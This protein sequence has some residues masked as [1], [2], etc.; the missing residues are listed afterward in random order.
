MKHFRAAF[1]A[2]LAALAL[3]LSGCAGVPG[4]TASQQAIRSV[5]VPAADGVAGALLVVPVGS[6]AGS[7][8]WPAVILYP[9]A[10]GLRPVFGELARSI[11]DHGYVVLVPN[12]FYRSVAFD[13]TAAT[14]AP[15]LPA[16]AAMQRGMGWRQ[17]ATDDAVIADARAF[18]SY[19]DALP[20]VDRTRPAAALGVDIGGAHAFMAAR[21]LPH[22]VAAVAV[23]HPS[24]IATAR[25]NSPHLFVGESRAAY[26][27]EIAGPDDV[28]EPEDKGDLASAFNAA[29][30]AA[31]VTVVPAGHG[32]AVADNG[33]FDAAARDAFVDAALVL[34]D[35]RLK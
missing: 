9:D 35:Q 18:M 5:S 31:E 15:P 19:L 33:E 23:A 32:Y 28:R 14:A 26:R 10:S 17:L 7:G 4:T 13:G 3:P 30:L 29:G 21:A 16:S 20:V 11:A 2:G 12:A 22:R 27:V 24:A 6:G 1:C 34:L 25:P 8:P